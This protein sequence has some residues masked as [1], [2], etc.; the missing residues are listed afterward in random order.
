MIRGAVGR[1][2]DDIKE[3][4]VGGHSH[5]VQRSIVKVRGPGNMLL[6]FERRQYFFLF[7]GVW[8]GRVANVDV[9]GDT[10]DGRARVDD[11][12]FE[13]RRQ[14]VEERK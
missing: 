5:E 2:D 1:I 3:A 7:T 6:H 13:D 11:E 8:V 14:L 10:D 12:D 4:A 9:V